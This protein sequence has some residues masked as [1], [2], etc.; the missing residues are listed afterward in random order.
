MK[1]LLLASQS[2]RRQQLLHDAGFDFEVVKIDVEEDFPDHL[3]AEEIPMFL[4]EKKANGYTGDLKDAI[5]ITADTTVWVDDKVLNKPADFNEAFAMIKSLSG[6]AHHVYT[7]VCL[8]TEGK[9]HTFFSDTE[10]YFANIPDE[11]IAYYINTYK[12][13]DKAG[14]YGIQEWI[15]YRFVQKINGCY[16]NVVGFPIAQFCREIEKF[17]LITDNR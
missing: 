3:K 6:R 5:V 13:Y 14:A 12:P 4:A 1:K 17:T 15:G 10:V 11:D 2:P 8:S 16:N 9:L 7:G